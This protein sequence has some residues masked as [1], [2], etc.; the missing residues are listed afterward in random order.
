MI[1][2]A[3]GLAALAIV[4]GAPVRGRL[5]ATVSGR[6]VRFLLRATDVSGKPGRV[7]EILVPRGRAVPAIDVFDARGARVAHVET[8]LG[9]DEAQAQWE[10]PL[11]L[12]GRF[13]AAP[14]RGPADIPAGAEKAVFT[15]E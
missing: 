2:Y 14:D 1:K 7:A 3:M 8:K 5:T 9:D 6:K 11:H 15:I 4:A 13:T 10:V 12:K